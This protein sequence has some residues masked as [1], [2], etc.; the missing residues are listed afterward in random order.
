LAEAISYKERQTAQLYVLFHNAFKRP[1][2]F[3]WSVENCVLVAQ[4]NN[5][6]FEANYI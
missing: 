2:G 1:K 5:L 6:L 4:R 3:I